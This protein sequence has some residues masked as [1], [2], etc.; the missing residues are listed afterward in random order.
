MVIDGENLVTNNDGV[1]VYRVNSTETPVIVLRNQQYPYGLEARSYYLKEKESSPGYEPL[2]VEYIRITIASTGEVTLEKASAPTSADGHWK[3]EPLS[4]NIATQTRDEDKGVITITIK[5]TPKDPVRIIKKDGNTKNP[6]AGVRFKLYKS[7]QLDNNLQPKPGQEPIING[8]TGDDGILS[9][10][11]IEEGVSI[12]YYLFETE[13]LPGYILLSGPVVISTSVSGNTTTVSAKLNNDD[14]SCEKVKDSNNK[15][16]W[17][18][19][20]ENT[21]GIVLPKTGGHGTALWTLVG[22]LLSGTAG[23]ILTIRRKK[24]RA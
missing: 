3:R 7:T 4:D 10:G 15:D 8:I 17:Q 6:L 12:S 22:T 24:R 1:I 2:G 19:T 21:P 18:I 5:N 11:G 13:T 9:L 16:V 14:L 23:A 20:V